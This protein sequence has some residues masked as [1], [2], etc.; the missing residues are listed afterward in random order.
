[1]LQVKAID[2]AV[3]V[4]EHKPYTGQRRAAV[5]HDIGDEIDDKANTWIVPGAWM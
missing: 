1:M 4:Q 3:L 5:T 2:E